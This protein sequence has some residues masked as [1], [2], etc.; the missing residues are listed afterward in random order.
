MRG[1]RGGR[2]SGG[3]VRVPDERW[4]VVAE[5]TG[6]GRHVVRGV[7]EAQHVF[8]EQ[9]AGGRITKAPIRSRRVR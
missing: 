5:V 9:F 7:G 4:V 2:A 1:R 8:A 6:E 3:A